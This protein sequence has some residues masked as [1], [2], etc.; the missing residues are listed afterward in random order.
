MWFNKAPKAVVAGGGEISSLL[1]S[2]AA[3]L[4]ASRP[5]AALS[6]Y[7]STP[8]I[9]PAKRMFGRFLRRNVL[10]RREGL[11]MKVLR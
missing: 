1:I 3:N 6:T 4:P 7:P 5:H 10:S 2:A 8:V 9:C 11:F